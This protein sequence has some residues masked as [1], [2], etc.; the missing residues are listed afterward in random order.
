MGLRIGTR[1]RLFRRRLRGRAGMT[2]ADM[3]E[4][5]ITVGAARAAWCLEH[6]AAQG[7]G[8]LGPARYSTA[9]AD[10]VCRSQRCRPVEIGPKHRCSTDNSLDIIP[11]RCG[12]GKPAL[13]TK[14]ELRE[15]ERT[16]PQT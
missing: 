5:Q 7:I 11:T 4:A 13:Q 14:L 15:R 6:P 10:H 16:Y 12:R 3:D 8:L 9:R 1:L 2:P